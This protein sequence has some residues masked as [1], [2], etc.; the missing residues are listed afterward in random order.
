MTFY[1]DKQWLY[2][3]T[4]LRDKSYDDKNDNY[5][6]ITNKAVS[7]MFTLFDEAAL[8][9]IRKLLDLKAIKAEGKGRSLSY[10]MA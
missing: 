9:E 8:K 2:K 4:C 10:V 6:S 1:C 3:E 7:E 5:G